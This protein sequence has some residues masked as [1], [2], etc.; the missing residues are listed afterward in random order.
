MALIA[1]FQLQVSRRGFYFIQADVRT[2]V[3]RKDFCEDVRGQH[4]LA[5]DSISLDVKAGSRAA[6]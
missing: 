5:L 3:P 6:C 1:V 4:R 2:G